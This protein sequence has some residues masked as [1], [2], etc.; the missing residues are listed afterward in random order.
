MSRKTTV[1]LFAGTALSASSTAFA[2]DLDLDRAYAAELRADAANRAS[3][4]QPVGGSGHNDEHGFHL[5]DGG[6]NLLSIGG[7]MQFRYMASFRDS[8]AAVLG[9]DNDT[10]IGFEVPRVRLIFQGTINNPNLSY[11]IDGDF[12]DNTNS[13]AAPLTG[14]TAGSNTGFFELHN[15]WGKYEFEGDGQ[16]W[17]VQF[18]QMKAPVLYEEFGVEDWHGMAVERSF[19]NELFTAGYTQ[20]IAVGYNSDQFRFA[21]VINDGANTPNSTYNTALANL[22]SDFGITGRVDFK[23]MGDWSQFA[24]MTSWQNSN[25]A[26]RIGGAFHYQHMGDT[27]PS[28]AGSASTPIEDFF[29]Y[30][31]DGSYEGN[32][33]GVY[34]AFVGNHFDFQGAS[35][36]A[37]LDNFGLM[38]QGNVFLT[39]EVELFGR[40]EAIWLDS[41]ITGATG[42]VGAI[43]GA[44]DDLYF[45]TAGINYYFIPESHAA[46]FTG[47]I[48]YA[49]NN[50]GVGTAGGFGVLPNAITGLQGDPA[51]DGEVLLRLQMQLVF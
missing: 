40:F 48:V 15:A 7:V 9:A 37:D 30:T 32:G 22:E 11:R 21:G 16:G 29:T 35:G 4:L 46:K 43:P 36:I 1:L 10:T 33:W 28:F 24:D 2:S 12:A 25:N 19:V 45:L 23:F 5:S 34:A 42:P 18:G 50:S 20:G 44:D 6:N 39:P 13:A 14:A 31:I 17:Y 51:S 27:N 38:V 41:G 3:L 26:A 49:F 47:D 8:G